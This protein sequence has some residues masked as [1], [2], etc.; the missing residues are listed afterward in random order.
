[1]ADEDGGREGQVN[2][3]VLAPYKSPELALGFM[4]LIAFFES[5]MVL[6]GHYLIGVCL[7]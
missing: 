7:V 4:P 6:I 2:S 1:M 3:S 5:G